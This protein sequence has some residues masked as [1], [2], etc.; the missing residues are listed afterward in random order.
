MM[1]APREPRIGWFTF[2]S[3][4]PS[5]S[6]RISFGSSLAAGSVVL[7]PSAKVV[8]EATPDT[9]VDAEGGVETEAGEIAT[10]ADTLGLDTAGTVVATRVEAVAELDA[11]PDAGALSATTTKERMDA[12]AGAS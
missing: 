10:E 11:G 12:K 4:A 2:S 5:G 3:P 6:Q 7:A 8:A 1:V 9:G